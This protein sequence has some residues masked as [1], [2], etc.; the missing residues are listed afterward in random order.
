MMIAGVKIAIGRT[1]QSHEYLAITTSVDNAATHLTDEILTK[2]AGFLAT[3]GTVSRAAPARW[4]KFLAADR[5]FH[6]TLYGASGSKRWVQ[7]IRTFW[8]K[9][10]RYMRMRTALAG[11]V[12]GVLTDHERILEACR[13]RDVESAVELIRDHISQAQEQLLEQWADRHEAT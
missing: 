3:M 1:A 8:L 2:M 9:A 7:T 5:S 4:D 11:G 12:A 6:L 10:E 13:R